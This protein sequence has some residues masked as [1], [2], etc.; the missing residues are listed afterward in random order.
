MSKPGPAA[1]PFELRALEGGGAG[2]RS[3]RPLD[4]T[5]LFRPE[6]GMPSVPKDL[7]V[8]ARKV[9][10]RLGPELLRYNLLSVVFSDAF[11]DLCETIADVKTLRRAL[12]ARQALMREQGKDEAEAWQATTPNGMPVQH[13]LALNLRNARADMQRLLDKFG[14]S[15]AEQASVTTAVRAQLQLFEAGPQPGG[16]KAQADAEKPASSPPTSFADF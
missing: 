7:S 12:R 13:P 16:G 15:P 14:L 1:K 8:G 6:V 4:V 2:G 9:W 3:H 11:E 10:K 5:G